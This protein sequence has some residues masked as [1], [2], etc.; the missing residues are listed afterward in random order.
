MKHGYNDERHGPFSVEF[1]TDS[2]EI[3]FKL[4]MP[5]RIFVDEGRGYEC[6]HVDGFSKL[7]S[8]WGYYSM[9]FRVIFSEKKYRNI[10][11]EMMENSVFSGVHIQENANIKKV[12][13]ESVKKALFLGDT[14]VTTTLMTENWKRR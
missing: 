9:G 14:N 2:Q 10:K 5:A 13:R 6:V 7:T 3:I 12:E 11:L 1:S 8:D 4:N